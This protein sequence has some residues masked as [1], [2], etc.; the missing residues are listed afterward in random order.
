MIGSEKFVES[1]GHEGISHFFIH[2][3]LLKFGV[4]HDELGDG[5]LEHHIFGSKYLLSNSSGGVGWARQFADQVKK[6]NDPNKSL[7]NALSAGTGAFMRLLFSNLVPCLSLSLPKVGCPKLPVWPTSW[8]PV[9][10]I[11]ASVLSEVAKTWILF[12][13]VSPS[14][15]TAPTVPGG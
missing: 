15:S 5:T 11:S 1:M 4:T 13:S 12:F 9:R 6:T 7:F 2:E 3:A 10:V 8:A 14:L